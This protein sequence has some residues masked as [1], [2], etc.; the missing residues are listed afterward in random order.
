MSKVVRNYTIVCP[1]CRGAGWI[2]NPVKVSSSAT[3]T[4]PA[5]N[6]NKTVLVAESEST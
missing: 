3:I 6:G 2:D 4:C 5:C 1:S